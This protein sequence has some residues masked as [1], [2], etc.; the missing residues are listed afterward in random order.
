[1]P[2]VFAAKLFAAQRAYIITS[3]DY[4]DPENPTETYGKIH[5]AGFVH[6]KGVLTQFTSMNPGKAITQSTAIK[7]HTK[8]HEII[9]NVRKAIEK[10]LI[11]K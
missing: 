7:S 6:Q 5:A 11:M 8:G 1:M 2:I 9:D 10:V 3:V 4:E